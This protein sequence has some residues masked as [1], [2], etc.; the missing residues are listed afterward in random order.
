[1]GKRN[2]TDAEKIAIVEGVADGLSIIELAGRIGVDR[3][4]LSGWLRRPGFLLD[5]VRALPNLEALGEES[6]ED[7]SFEGRF[8]SETALALSIRRALLAALDEAFPK[9]KAKRERK[10]RSLLRLLGG[11]T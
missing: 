3:S 8:E 9:W 1:M 11:R 2:L 7:V 4:T 5:A 10:R 6:L